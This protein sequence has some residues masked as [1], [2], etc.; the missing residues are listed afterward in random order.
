MTAPLGSNPNSGLPLATGS[1]VGNAEVG[2]G[3]RARRYIRRQLRPSDVKVVRPGDTLVLLNNRPLSIEHAEAIK[4][5]LATVMDGCQV[6]VFDQISG[7]AVMR[8]CMCQDNTIA[9]PS[10]VKRKESA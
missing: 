10:G 8:K 3:W 1:A 6:V 2:L 7:L 4:A 5:R 9:G